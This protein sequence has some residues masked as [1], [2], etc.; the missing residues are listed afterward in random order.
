LW[1]SRPVS[2]VCLSA[3]TVLCHFCSQHRSAGSF[4]LSSVTHTPSCIPIYSQAPTP[5]LTKSSHLRRLSVSPPCPPSLDGRAG[6]IPKTKI[7]FA[8]LM[9]TTSQEQYC[10]VSPCPPPKKPKT[11]LYSQNRITAS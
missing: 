5:Q 8:D 1:S 6:S 9:E 4:P 10:P 3:T 2:S 7:Q 11:P